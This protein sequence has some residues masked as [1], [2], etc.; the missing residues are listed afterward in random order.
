[1][2]TSKVC[3]I[4]NG[5]IGFTSS[6]YRRHESTKR[7]TDAVADFIKITAGTALE[8]MNNPLTEGVVVTEIRPGTPEWEESEI[9]LGYAAPKITEAEA[10]ELSAIN[11]LDPGPLPGIADLASDEEIAEYE[12]AHAPKEEPMT[13]DLSVAELKAIRMRQLW[14]AQRA[15]RRAVKAEEKA[16][17]SEESKKLAA[18][19]QEEWAKEKEAYAVYSAALKASKVKTAA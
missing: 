16:P 5:K 3:A 13:E 15:D 12:A 2:T 4:C 6:E 1:M 18:A 7:H 19:A 11:L 10:E 9:A 14:T 8:E 17:G